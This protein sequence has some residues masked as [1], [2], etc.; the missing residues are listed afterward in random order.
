MLN[1]LNSLAVLAAR[2]RKDVA[3][4][5]SEVLRLLWRAEDL[6][7][8]LSTNGNASPLRVLEDALEQLDGTLPR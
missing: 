8:R 3:A 7:S 6:V 4:Y 1:Q 5:L 2:E